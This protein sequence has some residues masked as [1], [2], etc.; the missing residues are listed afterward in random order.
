MQLE[1]IA[2]R[3]WALLDGGVLLVTVLCY[4]HGLLQRL[5]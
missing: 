2:W 4:L 5:R 3:L 1:V